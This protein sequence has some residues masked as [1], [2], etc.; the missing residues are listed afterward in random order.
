[1][2]STSA[3]PTILSPGPSKVKHWY[4]GTLFNAYVIGAVGFAAPGL[5]NAMNALGA[6]GA[7]SPYLVNLANAL[8]FGLMALFVSILR[9]SLHIAL[10]Q[11]AEYMSL[12]FS[13]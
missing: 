11:F 4:R 13:A 12:W 7:R 6:G 1:M 3:T 8:V 2:S 9:P 10:Y 5:W